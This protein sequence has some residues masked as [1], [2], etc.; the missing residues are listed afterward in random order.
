MILS[1]WKLLVAKP[2]DLSLTS[3]LYTGHSFFIPSSNSDITYPLSFLRLS[4]VRTG[5]DMSPLC[6]PQGHCRDPGSWGWPTVPCLFRLPQPLPS[7]M[8]YFAVGSEFSQ[9]LRWGHRIQ[10]CREGHSF[11]S[12]NV[13]QWETRLIPISPSLRPNP[14]QF[15]STEVSIQSW[16]SLMW[17]R[18]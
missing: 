14:I 18:F 10:K 11:Y 1:V 3:D 13:K 5:C 16:R 15:Q 4:R 9:A 8:K 2:L 17:P 6:P 12:M 7:Q